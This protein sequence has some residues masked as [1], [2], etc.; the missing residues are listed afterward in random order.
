MNVDV[1]NK[2]IRQLWR[3]IPEGWSVGIDVP[4]KRPYCATVVKGC[5]IVGRVR[6][7]KPDGFFRKTLLVLRRLKA[8]Q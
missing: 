7:S 3:E 6:A 1:A 4:F 2:A 5:R 8:T